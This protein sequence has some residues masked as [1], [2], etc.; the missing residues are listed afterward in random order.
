M[1]LAYEAEQCRLTTPPYFNRQI[2]DHASAG[3]PRGD[4]DCVAQ[5]PITEDK[6]LQH[7]TAVLDR[8]VYMC[9]IKVR[10]GPQRIFDFIPQLLICGPGAPLGCWHHRSCKQSLLRGGDISFESCAPDQDNKT[11]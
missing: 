6:A 7:N 4:T 5:I 11:R 10:V 9:A 1:R 2:V 3:D 8:D